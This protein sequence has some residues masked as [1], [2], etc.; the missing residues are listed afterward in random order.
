MN[1][2]FSCLNFHSISS[3]GTHSSTEMI[4][5]YISILILVIQGKRKYLHHYTLCQNCNVWMVKGL[6]LPTLDN[7]VAHS[8]L[9]GCHKP[10]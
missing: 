10:V 6:E 5:K 2:E 3:Q 9:A 7:E 1:I 8:T 4:G